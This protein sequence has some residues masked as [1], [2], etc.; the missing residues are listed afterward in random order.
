M[1]IKNDESAGR[2]AFRA[3][4][5]GRAVALVWRSGRGWAASGIVLIFVQGLLPLLTLYLMKLVVDAVSA[6]Q[7]AAD[8]EAAFG[9]AA[10]YIA[11]MGGVA[12]LG[13]LC[14]LAA[15]FIREAQ[16]Q[17]VSD[18]MHDVLHSKSIEVDLEYYENPRYYDTLHRAQREAPYRP[19][20]IVNGLVQ[21]GQSGVSLLAMVALLFSFHWAV[22][23]VLLFATLPGVLVR[24]KFSAKLYRWQRERTSAERRSA[25]YGWILTGE[26]YAKEVRLFGLGPLFIGRFRELRDRLRKEKLGLSAHRSAWELAAQAIAIVA[27][28]GSYAFIARRAVEG[29]ITLG[30]LV[31]YFQAFQRGQGYLRD[32]L[33]GLAGLYEDNLFLANLYE[34]LDLEPKVI[35]PPRPKALPKAVKSGVVFSGV[36]FT[37]PG[38]TQKVL[39][40]VDLAV[41]P[42]EVIALVGANGSGKTTLVKLLC[43]LYDPTEGSVTLDGVDLRKTRIADLRRRIGVIFQD[44][45]EYYLSA[46]ENIRLGDLDLSPED[47]RTDERIVEAARLSGADEAITRLPEGYGT[48]L[49]KMFEGSRELSVGEWQKVALARALLRDSRIV[50]LDE[51]TSAMDAR[52]EAEFFK[53]FRRI[54]EG[55]AAVLVSHRF[56]TVRTADRIHVLEGGRIVESGS[57]EELMRR[58]GTYRRFFEA[59]QDGRAT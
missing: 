52:A 36:S 35:D 31:M 43:R 21:L 7:N 8:K 10:L 27:V 49:G 11:L 53:N 12:L 56:S 57:H 19:T 26:R 1:P 33:G 40:G 14:R 45:A 23:L 16:A 54:A 24:L 38:G 3:L 59:Q 32:L 46:R 20:R 55:R 18:R 5:L 41:R 9:G 51:P 6:G 37:Y 17:A 22:A 4:R 15:G 42:G 47:E 39:N 2:K 34:F 30:D 50:V 29:N 44:Y 13:A 28:F 58:G 25:Y 48:I